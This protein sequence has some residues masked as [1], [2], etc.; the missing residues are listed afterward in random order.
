MH[1]ME[2]ARPRA[3]RIPGMQVRKAG[4]TAAQ[5]GQGC[6]RYRG[7]V[8]NVQQDAGWQVWSMDS[9]CFRLWVKGVAW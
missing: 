8:V 1:A 9:V 3:M 6:S 2:A 5:Q 4:S 7:G